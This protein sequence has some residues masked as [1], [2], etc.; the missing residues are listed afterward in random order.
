M[1]KVLEIIMA[2]GRFDIYVF[3]ILIFLFIRHRGILYQYAIDNIIGLFLYVFNI[4]LV[5]SVKVGYFF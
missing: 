2:S 5:F 4:L 3:I 1:V